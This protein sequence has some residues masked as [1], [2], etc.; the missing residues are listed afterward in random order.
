M[1]IKE[2]CIQID[3]L[4]NYFLPSS[5][6][7][8]IKEYSINQDTNGNDTVFL[9][10]LDSWETWC[11]EY[12]L[13]RANLLL[14][15]FSFLLKK[16]FH[17]TDLFVRVGPAS[18][19]IYAVG[20]YQDEDIQRML[21][22]LLHTI[23]DY[24][25]MNYRIHMGI[26][27]V[28][29]EKEFDSLLQCA[30]RVLAHAMKLDELYAVDHLEDPM[31]VTLQYP[32]EI[33]PYELDSQDID[34]AYVSDM[35]SFLFGCM[36]LNFGIEMVLSRMCEYF[37]VQQIYV[38]EKDFDEG[39]YTI[40]HDW[41]CEGVM[42]E[43]D[44]F[45]KLPLY[46]GDQ[47][48]YSFDERSLLVCNQLDDL[49]KFNSFI[50]LRNKIR[51]ARSLLQST[52]LENGSYIGFLCMLDM[53]KE[54]VWTAKEIAT[55]STLVKI[56]NT[57]ILQLRTKKFQRIVADRDTL[58]SAWNLN[59]FTDTVQKRLS[60]EEPKALITLDIKNFKFINTEYGYQYGNKI[61]MSITQILHMFIE[62]PDCFA[63][64]DADTFILLLFYHDLNLLKQ[65]LVSLTKKIEQCTIS[66][67]E[68]ARII[69]M[70]GVYLIEDPNKTMAEMMDCANTARKSIKNTHQSKYAF[71][72]REIEALNI[73]EHH[74][75]QIMKQS[76][77]NKEFVV[78]YQPKINIHTSRCT[79]L[80]ALVRWK[81]SE[82]EIIP[83]NDFIPLFERNGF[84]TEIDLFVLETVCIQIKEWID[85]GKT[86]LPIAVNISRVH[87]EQ[88]D[89]VSQIIHMCEKYQ[90]PP[91]FIELE[92]TES[93]FLENEVTV[94]QKAKELKT[95]G[96]LLSMD[97]FGTGF[98]SLNLLKELPVDVLKLDKAFFVKIIDEREKIIL[99]NI[100]H[101]AL[102]LNMTVISEGIE[103]KRQVAFL[104]E[105]GCS[106]A[107]GYYYSR[108]YPMEQLR[109][110]LWNEFEGGN[111]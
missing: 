61:L 52:L 57:S 94:I 38:M 49:Y 2:D 12:D 32:M 70:M 102:Q 26:Y 24:V 95:A 108:P 13:K 107:Q 109:N 9:I 55:F 68:Q 31:E 8:E 25:S 104:K 111:L 50:A 75:T 51:G 37:Q 93:A 62:A 54:R 30:Q 86:P 1:R 58:T 96:F 105:I 97:D 84:I 22:S 23:T 19:F 27:H 71:F 103:T 82:T 66:Y 5:A 64:V 81:R 15:K 60:I 90:I 40:T 56:L 4:T 91:V 10:H 44:N 53:K 33:P 101:M 3:S 100:V 48:Q 20:N 6:R 39:G 69:C 46:I 83:P 59:K 16:L 11:E 36:D 79:G 89:I 72:N 34:M 74:L 87:L 29:D 88:P 45:K 99:T 21:H 35:T 14:A 77:Q 80:E 106:I 41:I 65:R 28:Q 42:V 7:Q 73:R 110:H 67:D 18:F 76:L 17:K 47:Y 78:Y 85:E 43:N 98:S 63:R 92:I